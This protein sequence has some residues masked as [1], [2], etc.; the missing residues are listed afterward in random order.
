PEE[1]LLGEV[2]LVAAEAPLVALDLGRGKAAE[3]RV[4]VIQLA[5]GHGEAEL[6]VGDG[7]RERLRVVVAEQ[8]RD[9]PPLDG[10][11]EAVAPAAVP[12][13]GKGENTVSR[14]ELVVVVGSEVR[15][16]DGA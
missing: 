15:S 12:G 2:G 4:E 11:E 6:V 5:L 3:D 9:G 7:V 13:R 8:H 10:L 1:R 16:K 14:K